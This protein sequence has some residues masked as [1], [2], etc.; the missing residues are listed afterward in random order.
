MDIDTFVPTIAQT[1]GVSFVSPAPVPIQ[2]V[3]GA[4]FLC[5]SHA[6]EKTVSMITIV[7]RSVP[8]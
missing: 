3:A 6:I 5:K 7:T 1:L 4:P 8:P 2:E